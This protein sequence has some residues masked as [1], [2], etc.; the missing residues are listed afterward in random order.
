MSFLTG[1]KPD[2][3][4][5]KIYEVEK[6]KIVSHFKT[7]RLKGKHSFTVERSGK[8]KM[9]IE[10]SD[11]EWFTDPTE[12][13][14]FNFIID[15]DQDDSSSNHLITSLD[16]NTAAK[17]KEFEFVNKKMSKAKKRVIKRQFIFRSRKSLECSRTKSFRKTNFLRRN[18]A[19]ARESF[20]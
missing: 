10:G 2:S 3:L 8:Y 20:S 19:T 9:C 18:S 5:I 7:N 13:I 15:T 6:S 12:K 14:K 17:N 11:P 1:K 16:V 4:E